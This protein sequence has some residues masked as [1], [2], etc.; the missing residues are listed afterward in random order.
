M[1]NIQ[2]P[3]HMLSEWT[4]IEDWPI[5][6]NSLEEWLERKQAWTEAQVMDIDPGE[7]FKDK[8]FLA[9][10]LKET[11]S[12]KERLNVHNTEFMYNGSSYGLIVRYFIY[13]EGHIQLLTYKPNEIKSARSPE[14]KITYD[15][16]KVKLVYLFPEL[17]ADDYDETTA[18]VKDWI[19]NDFRWIEE[20]L[21]SINVAFDEFNSDQ[22][23]R[24]IG[25]TLH[26]RIKAEDLLRDLQSEVLQESHS[27]RSEYKSESYKSLKWYW[28]GI[29]EGQCAGTGYDMLYGEATWDHIIPKSR[30]EGGD[31]DTWDNL[32][33]LCDKCN[34]L[35]DNRSQEEYL[36]DIQ[37]E[38]SHCMGWERS[39]AE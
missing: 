1:I 6:I 14:V 39:Q 3:A 30:Y 23:P 20:C 5:F 11:L 18:I 2:E 27:Q 25:R 24:I 19:R 22:L 13:M 7:L 36:S 37:T 34:N 29:Q 12:I 33:L 9:K 32:Q 28:F 21:D 15:N 35:K 10:A 16:E 31:P 4:F 17:K 38:L 26:K 8:R